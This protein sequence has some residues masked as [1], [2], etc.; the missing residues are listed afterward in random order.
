[1]NESL[2]T[3]DKLQLW[4]VPRNVNLSTLVCPLCNL[5]R[6]SHSHLFFECDFAANL[7]RR[8]RSL[9]AMEDVEPDLK[10]IIDH[11]K[12]L[13]HRN[14]FRSI[15]RRLILGAS[16]YFVWLERNIRVFKKGSRIVEQIYNRIYETVRFYYHYDLKSRLAREVCWLDGRYIEPIT[17]N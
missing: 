17:S 4:D 3:Q 15:V 13:S 8:V 7:W 9:A 12:P 1:M 5:V 11:L 16:A 6:D 14:L 10:C 2:K